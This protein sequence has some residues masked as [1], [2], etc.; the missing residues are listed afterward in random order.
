MIALIARGRETESRVSIRDTI[1]VGQ[2]VMEERPSRQH[3]PDIL[4]LKDVLR[5]KINIV[6]IC[7]YS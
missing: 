1:L 4:S 6:Y 3:L 5:H 7:H 2:L